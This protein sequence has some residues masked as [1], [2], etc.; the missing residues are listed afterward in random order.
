M[1]HEPDGQLLYKKLLKWIEYH[2]WVWYSLLGTYFIWITKMSKEP[3]SLQVNGKTWN[4]IYLDDKS[5]WWYEHQ[6][7]F[8]ELVVEEG[9][10]GQ[11]IAYWWPPEIDIG[12]PVHI[13]SGHKTYPEAM[14]AAHA[15]IDKLKSLLGDEN[16]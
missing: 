6:G 4:K 14:K 5:G 9:R 2:F 13:S 15:Y 1:E 12:E 11:M 8:G 16:D 10:D 3:E 7:L